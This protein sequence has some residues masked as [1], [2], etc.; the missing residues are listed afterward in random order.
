MKD[1]IFVGPQIA[2]L[3]EYQEFNFHIRTVHLDITKLNK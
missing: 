2:Q 3:F 1:G